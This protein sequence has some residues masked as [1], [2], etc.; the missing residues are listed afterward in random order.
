MK[1]AVILGIG[2]ALAIAALPHFSIL[3]ARAD[4]QGIGRAFTTTLNLLF[5]LILPA[6]A[7]IIVLREPIIRLIFERGA[8]TLEA[9]RLTADALLYYALG[10]WA[11]AGARIAVA[12]LHAVQDFKTPLQAALICIG[13]NLLCGLLLM[14]SMGHR[15]LA[16]AISIAAAVNFFLLFHKIDRKFSL[17]Y[18][19]PEGIRIVNHLV[20]T[21]VMVLGVLACKG[22]VIPDRGAS[23]ISL[24]FGLG[25]CVLLGAG[26]YAVTALGLKNSSLRV[27]IKAVK[28]G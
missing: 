7:G 9:S 25:T 3:A 18:K 13:V 5:F 1:G 19:I 16:L 11:I 14:K 2:V 28:R 6:S 27:I 17:L 21:A 10:I 4:R 24:A 26:V 12:A 8:F 23:A 20:C 22:I 15:G